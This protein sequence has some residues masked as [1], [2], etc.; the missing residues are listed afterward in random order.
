MSFFAHG[1]HARRFP[2]QTKPVPAE[3]TAPLA[4]VPVPAPRALDETCPFPANAPSGGPHRRPSPR[5][6]RP[7]LAVPSPVRDGVLLTGHARIAESFRFGVQCSCK[8]EHVNVNVN[9]FRELY[10]SAEWARWR[11]DP[12]GIWRCPRCVQRH[13]TW[14][15]VRPVAAIEGSAA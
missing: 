10:I 2:V 3:H 12:F 9:T 5:H 13:E 11:Q 15:G 4:K 8:R 14:F 7:Y 6:G 1:K